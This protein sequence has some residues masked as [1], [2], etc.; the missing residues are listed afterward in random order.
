MVGWIVRRNEEEHALI[1]LSEDAVAMYLLS[2]LNCTHHTIGWFF[3]YRSTRELD[4][5]SQHR[6]FAL[7]VSKGANQS[8]DPFSTS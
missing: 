3:K 7:T 6:A 1:P 8:F 2:G 5:K 4:L